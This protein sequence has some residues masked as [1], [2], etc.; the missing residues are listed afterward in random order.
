MQPSVISAQESV[1]RIILHVHKDASINPKS[2]KLRQWPEPKGPERYVSVNRY[3]APSLVADLRRY[4]QGRNLPCAMM[5]VGEIQSIAL[6]LDN[7]D[8]FPVKY[9]VRDVSSDAI[10]S[11]AGI[12]ITVAGVPLEGSGDAVFSQINVGGDKDSK[13]LAIRRALT[14]IATKSLTTVETL[15]KKKEAEK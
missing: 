5:N 15:C 12:F 9:E 7:T 10:P 13:V 11:H 6:F 1:V 3:E 4:D 2:F 8:Q 14:D